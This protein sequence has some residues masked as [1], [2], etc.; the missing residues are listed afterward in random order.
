MI[1]KETI[2]KHK[3]FIRYGLISAFVTVIDVIV[4]RVCEQFTQ[5]VIANTIGVVTGFIIQYFL[6]A[7]YVYNTRSKKSFLIFL[8]TFFL[9]LLMANAIVFVLRTFVFNGSTE[10]IPFL[11]S[12]AASIVFPFFISYYI[13][14]RVM[15]SKEAEENE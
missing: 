14:K 11:V 1:L 15:P 7:K 10:R 3:A 5:V 12:K 2:Q 8:A 4:C 13:R 6:T 9:N